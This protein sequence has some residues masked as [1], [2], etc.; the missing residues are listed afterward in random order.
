[1]TYENGATHSGQAILTFRLRGIN[2]PLRQ[3]SKGHS[4]PLGTA[5]LAKNQAH[6]HEFKQFPN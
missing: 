4:R 1:M 5:R 2:V 6:T 3:A